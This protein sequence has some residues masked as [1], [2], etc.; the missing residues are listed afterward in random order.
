M[1]YPIILLTEIRIA[2]KEPKSI[3]L[4]TVDLKNIMAK[5]YQFISSQKYHFRQCSNPK[6]ADLPPYMHVLSV[7]LG[8][9]SWA[10]YEREK[11]I[12]TEYR[13]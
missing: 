3:I 8:A 2:S 13:I 5:I 7:S 1:K 12:P 11:G 4:S 6:I 9:D 10:L